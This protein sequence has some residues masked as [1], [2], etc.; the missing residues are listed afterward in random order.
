VNEE[1]IF[2]D[3]FGASFDLDL[4]LGEKNWPKVNP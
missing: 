3:F 1:A 2:G 4:D